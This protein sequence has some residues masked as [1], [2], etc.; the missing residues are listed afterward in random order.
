[1]LGGFGVTIG[2]NVKGLIK[3]LNTAKTELNKF[4][5]T[6]TAIRRGS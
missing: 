5:S 2:A 4:A 1:M 3:G 6:T